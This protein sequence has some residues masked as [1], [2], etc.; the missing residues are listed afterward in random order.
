MYYIHFFQND[1]INSVAKV[2]T[3]TAGGTGAGAASDKDVLSLRGKSIEEKYAQ[4][5]KKNM[6]NKA[7]AQNR[8]ARMKEELFSNNKNKI[9]V[10]QEE[11]LSKLG[12]D[13][14]MNQKHFYP[15]IPIMPPFQPIDNSIA[16]AKGVLTGNKPTLAGISS[17]LQSF[18]SE[19]HNEN[20]KNAHDKAD[21][22][23]VLTTYFDLAQKHLAP[24][25]EA[26]RSKA[27]F[28][29][30]D[31]ESIYLSLASFREHLL[32]ETLSTA[33]DHAAHPDKL[34][35]GAIVQNCFG[36]VNADGSID[37][38]GKPCRT[39]AQVV[40]KN[41]KGRDMTK[42]SDAPVDKN[43]IADFCGDAKYKKYCDSG[44][45]RVLY[46]HETESIGPAIA[47][48][49]ASKLWGGE[50]YFVQ[51]DSHLHFA[52][53]WDQKY[54]DEV[55]SAK[56]YPK[57]VLSSYPPGFTEGQGTGEVN[58]SAGARLCTCQFSTSDVENKIIR[59]NT[60]NSY[61]GN[62]KHPTQIAFIAAGFFFAHSQFLV[63]VPFDPFMPWLFMG[64]E[65]ALS[66][67]AWTS[68]WDIYAPRK[69]LISH[70]YRPGRMG[71]PKFWGS[72]NRLYGRPMNNGLQGRVID[73]VK[74]LVGYPE[75]TDEIVK[76]RGD[77]IVLTDR[78]HYGLGSERTLEE[79]MKLTQIDVEK[80]ECRK[81]I[82]CNQGQLE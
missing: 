3:N 39:G 7:K 32:Y 44:Q 34:Y 61:S 35:I 71:L 46:V 6:E 10:I 15:P 53:H 69:N 18:L 16:L 13:G 30:R 75:S 48:Y 11:L 9:D 5:L 50:T 56:S 60:G 21:P 4:K 66:V 20:M 58:E 33:F 12:K 57:A 14:S 64:E 79:Y 67:R 78:E 2:D 31:D 36:K 42:V 28:P 82:W 70:Q 55:K 41:K 73:R 45:I 23:T 65:I 47:R 40:G 19:F 17:L 54:I 68:G 62:E 59:I 49:Y 74:N 77:E 38:S 1:V 72:V 80:K 26:Y 81:M 24:L 22:D 52:T 25:D 51:C 76:G 27:V 43:G 8:E 63:D 29:I 37:A